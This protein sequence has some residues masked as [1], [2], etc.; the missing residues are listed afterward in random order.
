MKFEWT[1]KCQK[2]FEKLK[3]YLLS[4]QILK[5]PDFTKDFTITTDASNV[6]C[7]AVLSQNYDGDDLPIA[8]ASK[9]F[10]QAESRKHTIYQEMIAIHWA[11]NH[12]K[13]YI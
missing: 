6:A 1:D 8:Y 9:T 2:T 12:F 7:G 4:P 5:Y 10:N 3:S 11:I 13:P